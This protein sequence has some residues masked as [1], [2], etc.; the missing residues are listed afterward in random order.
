VAGTQK[1]SAKVAPQ[2]GKSKKR[3]AA[4][5]TDEAVTDT[6]EL[7]PRSLKPRQQRK[8]KFRSDEDPENAPTGTVYAIPKVCQSHELLTK[9]LTPSA[10]GIAACCR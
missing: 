10:E 2:V 7:P 1:K 6:P 5:D 8:K 4:D 3:K 9:L